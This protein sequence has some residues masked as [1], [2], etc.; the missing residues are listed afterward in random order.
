MSLKI[1]EFARIAQVSGRLLRH[2]DDLG[3]FKPASIDP[4]TGY[5]RYTL[6]QLPQLHRIL[7]LRDLG[8]PLGEVQHL[9][10]EALPSPEI[11]RLLA[12]R[13]AHLRQ[14]MARLHA[15]LI[16]VETRLALI[17]SAGQFPDHQVVLKALPA[18][19]GWI[20]AEDFIPPRFVRLLF[21][22]T[23]PLLQ[24]HGYLTHIKGLMTCYHTPYLI[25]EKH[26][27]DPAPYFPAEAIYLTHPSAPPEDIA[28]SNGRC[29]RFCQLPAFE[30]AATLIHQG[31][32]EQRHL[33]HQWLHSWIKQRGYKLAAPIREVY[34]NRGPNPALYVTELQHPLR[35]ALG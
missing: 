20:A 12:L 8:I 34:L 23:Y 29:L 14:E 9:L 3:L 19:W 6:G 7:A 21:Q 31:P 15:Q 35:P 32:D 2:Y 25:Q 5:R 1:G 28:L 27:P 30:L 10:K 18:Q 4:E 24:K 13:H 17:Q 26:L 33:A 16:Q 22:E 11:E